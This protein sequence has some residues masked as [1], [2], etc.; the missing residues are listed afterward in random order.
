MAG[1]RLSG[2]P[3]VLFKVGMRVLCRNIYQLALEPHTHI[4]GRL[5]GPVREKQER[6][7]FRGPPLVPFEGFAFVNHFSKPFVK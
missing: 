1:H 7:Y 4:G 3:L 2:F 6:P 5:A